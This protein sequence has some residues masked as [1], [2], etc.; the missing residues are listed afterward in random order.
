MFTHMYQL[1]PGLCKDIGC[2]EHLTCHNFNE[3]NQ[4]EGSRA[5]SMVLDQFDLLNIR[6]NSDYEAKPYWARRHAEFSVFS[7]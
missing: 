4:T 2:H 7:K 5:V 1:K 3:P 6:L